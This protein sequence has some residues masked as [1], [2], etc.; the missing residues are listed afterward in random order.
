MVASKNMS[1]SL[2]VAFS[3]CWAVTIAAWVVPSA[4]DEPVEAGRAD[5]GVQVA[6]VGQDGPPHRAGPA[7][8]ESNG[9]DPDTE[10]ASANSGSAD[11]DQGQPATLLAQPR[12]EMAD[13][14]I[15][16]LHIDNWELATFLEMLSLQSRRNIITSPAVQGTVRAHLYDVTFEQALESILA[17]NE[18]GYRVEGNFIY[19]HTYD[20]LSTFADAENPP[21]SRVFTL[22]YIT[23]AD[24]QPAIIPILSEIG[25]ISASP[26][27]QMGIATNPEEAGGNVL[28]TSDFVVV[29]DR[30]ARLEEIAKVI[31][32]LDV[33]PKQVLIEATILR[34]QL[35]EENAL[36]IDFAL[37][38]GVDLSG[39][40]ATSNAISDLVLGPLPA[41]RFE[42]FN[43][44]GTTNL[45]GGFPPGGLTLGVIKDHVAVFLR[46]L[47]SVADTTVIANP[48]VLALNKQRGEVIVGREDGYPVITV[49]ET[50]SIQTTALV[51]TGTRLLFRPFISDDG[52]IRMELHPEDSVGGVVGDQP[53]KETTEVTTNVL[54]RDGQTI[55]IG[56]LFRDAT[57]AKHTQVPFLGEIPFLGTWFRSTE[58]S[59]AREEVIILLT[60]H[61]IK[62]ADG[63]ARTGADQ[64][65]SVERIRLGARRGV[66]WHGRE[67]L[68]QAHYRKALER[69]AENDLDKALWEVRMTLHSNSRFL[70]ALDLKEQILGIREWEDDGTAT[71]QFIHDLITKERLDA[72]ILQPLRTSSAET[73]AMVLQGPQ[74]FTENRK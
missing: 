43:A 8:P 58:D 14:L 61:I 20:E 59:S 24:V 35:S 57:S 72:R 46:A 48:K 52:W 47:E 60:V 7:E 39:L 11:A 18:A 29:Y 22:N 40:G 37:T 17:S 69:F 33:R 25:A 19:V 13:G 3:A 44:A 27:A 74:G 10:D 4:A 63:Y 62:D 71:R 53:F 68:A 16:E 49:T 2:I 12:V 50:A 30:P 26:P 31:A 42:F 34:V 56:G 9:S 55:L 67:R 51:K 1:L 21:Q 41:E 64:L 28:A 15:K 5:S 36:G 73:S 70:P 65:Q 54:L 66:M 23:A 32:A 45:T 38:G 6:V